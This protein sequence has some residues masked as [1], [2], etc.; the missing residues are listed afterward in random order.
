MRLHQSC[1]DERRVLNYLDLIADLHAGV[2]L[3]LQFKR[4][5]TP[6]IIYLQQSRTAK[7]SNSL[8]PEKNMSERRKIIIETGAKDEPLS[9]PHFDTEATLTARPV[10][11]LADQETY[12][13]NYGGHS[14]R[15]ARPSWKRPALLVPIVLVAVGIGVVAGLAIGIYRNRSAAQPTPVATAPT[16][17]TENT[18]LSQTAEPPTP[19]PAPT[20]TPEVRVAVPA[21]P[22]E[23]PAVEPKEEERERRTARNER[24]DTD[25]E[26]RQPVVARPPVVRE[27]KPI[28][29]DEYIIEDDDDR[30]AAREQ[31]REERR[32]ERRER[33]RRGREDE[34]NAPRGIQRAGREVERI[35]EIFEGRQP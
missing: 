24:K 26:A 34:G 29:I 27:K 35:R 8:R 23:E 33:R 1:G 5:L 28:K 31:R 14:A 12:P 17:V 21:E 9:T 32:A 30:Q 6:D 13:T 3:I 25:D 19:P 11:P 10:V 2:A 7:F 18:D 20:P 4:A 16:P 15:A 22:E